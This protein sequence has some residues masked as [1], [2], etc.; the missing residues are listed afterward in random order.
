MSEFANYLVISSVNE[1][2]MR[3]R[4]ADWIERISSALARRDH[5]NRLHYS[6][7]VHPC[8]IAGE[9]CLVVARQLE[10]LDPLAYRYI[11]DFAQANKLRIQI[12]RRT[13]DRAL[14]LTSSCPSSR[15]H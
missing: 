15:S 11:M 6:P 12:D 14:P 1:E 7:S 8:Y 4:P 10:E 2:G 13:D 3:F 9:K 5:L